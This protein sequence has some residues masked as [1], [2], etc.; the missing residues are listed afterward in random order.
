MKYGSTVNGLCSKL[1]SDLDLTVITK[2]YDPETVL[3]DVMTILDKY[4]GGRYQ[5]YTYLPRKDRAG[6][7]VKC[8]DIQLETDI[9]LMVNK[10]SEVLNSLLILQ[11]S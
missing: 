9:D 8:R 7:I 5:M 6:W 4:G 1:N 11:Y 10:N 2:H 3:T